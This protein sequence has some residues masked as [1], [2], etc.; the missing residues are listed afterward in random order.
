MIDVTPTTTPAQPVTAAELRAHLRLNDQGED[1]L[2]TQFIA[3]AVEQFETE[4]DRPV[5]ATTYRQFLT[6]WPAEIVLG[7][8]GVS[9]VVAV[10]RYLADGSTADVP[11]TWI[12]DLNTTP[13]RVILHTPPDL[14][15]TATGIPVS[16]VGYVE[17]VAGWANTAAVP[18]AVLVAVKQL[19]GHLYQNREAYRDSAFEMRTVP[20]GWQRVCQKYKLRL[21]GRWRQ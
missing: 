19:A 6:R 5:L 8:G 10:K 15:A 20:D 14:V 18:A 16:P 4:T 1:T 12:A 7:R 21:F 3:A 11:T 9:S 13:A 2:L 17:F